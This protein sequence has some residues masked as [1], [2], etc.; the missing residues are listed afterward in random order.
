M[1]CNFH[2]SLQLVGFPGDVSKGLGSL[3]NNMSNHYKAIF[4]IFLGVVLIISLI[5]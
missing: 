4:I 3:V 2:F 1:M 5:A